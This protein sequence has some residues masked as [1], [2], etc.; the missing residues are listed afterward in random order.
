MFT[1]DQE[2]RLAQEICDLDLLKGYIFANADFKLLAS[3][4]YFRWNLINPE[5]ERPD[6]KQFRASNGFIH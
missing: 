1:D 5:A 2:E 6:Y 4:A 3:H